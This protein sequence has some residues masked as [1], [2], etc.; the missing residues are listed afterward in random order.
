[1]PELDPATVALLN[2]LRLLGSRPLAG[3]IAGPHRSSR[4]GS[5]LEFADY[6]EYVR[7]DDPRR[8]DWRALARLDR[9]YVREY[10]DERDRVVHLLLD[11]SASL[12]F[13]GKDRC[14]K[15][16]AAAL[17]YVAL[18]QG[19]RVE[20]TLLRGTTAQRLVSARGPAGRSRVARALSSLDAWQGTTALLPALL[21]WRGGSSTTT[22]AGIPA[23]AIPAGTGM[24]AP[25]TPA[26]TGVAARDVAGPGG[27]GSSTPLPVPGSGRT[28]AGGIAILISDL[29]DPAAAEPGE[30]A[31]KIA[32][33]LAS[34]GE[35]A[36]VQ[37]LAPDELDPEPWLA[38]ERG[39]A[40]AEWT[41]VDSETGS[42]REVTADDAV[43]ASYRRALTGWLGAWR[44]ACHARGVPHVLVSSGRP[45]RAVILEELVPAG[46]VA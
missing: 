15:E 33:V 12:G 18:R 10:A 29:L 37:V 32:A 39:R 31:R 9:P 11:G 6:R 8:L 7:G 25:A 38:G 46:I 17:A 2:R 23:T 42:T 5:S 28:A 3:R 21:A 40:T 13:G 27:A 26:G 35:G 30:Y 43:L 36:V 4:K 20:L 16:L 14:L 41:L 45:L 1:M 44:A 34:A 22:P 19:D 24:T